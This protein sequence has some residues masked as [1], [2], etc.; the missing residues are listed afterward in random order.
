M[1]GLDANN[2]ALLKLI[3]KIHGH[4]FIL[5]I[6]SFFTRQYLFINST[7]FTRCLMPGTT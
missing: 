3:S 4:L 1:S 2:R 6:N 7:E 5:N